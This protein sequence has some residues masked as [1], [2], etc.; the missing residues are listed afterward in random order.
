MRAHNEWLDAQTNFIPSNVKRVTLVPTTALTV[1]V[2]KPG[3]RMLGYK[4][5][6]H[7]V[8]IHDVVK[9]SAESES[10]AVDVKLK[11]PKFSPEIVTKVPPDVH[12][13]GSLMLF[14]LICTPLKKKNRS[15]APDDGKFA[16]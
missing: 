1:T 6:I 14:G 5:D 15:S 13:Q 12:M 3:T 16:A 11:V 2:F 7:D 9:H 8:D 4:H 10:A